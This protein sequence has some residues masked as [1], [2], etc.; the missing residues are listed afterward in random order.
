M[1][2][3]I[4]KKV[5]LLLSGFIVVIVVVGLVCNLL[6]LRQ[7]YVARNRLV[8][9]N[10]GNEVVAALQ[11]SGGDLEETISQLD[12]DN[13]V[14][15]RIVDAGG[16]I[17]ATSF[18]GKKKATALAD[19]IQDMISLDKGRR[20]QFAFSKV[21]NENGVSNLVHIRRISGGRYLV[22]NK[23]IKG[24]DESAA[25]ANRFYLIVGAGLILFGGGVTMLFSRAITKP[26]VEMSR[27]TARIAELDFSE[28]VQVDT[29]DELGALGFS[30]N[31]ISEKLS[32]S[33][34]RLRGDIARRKRLV[35]DLSHELKTPIAVIKGYA[36]GL[37]YGVA[38]DE[39][40]TARY[41][42]VI[43][44]ECDRMDAQIQQLLELS[45]LENEQLK[46]D[47]HTISIRG[48]FDSLSERFAREAEQKHIRLGFDA[49]ESLNMVA[50]E[51]MIGRAVE[52][53]LTNALRHTPESGEIRVHAE[54]EAGR[55]RICVFN[56][57]SHLTQEQ[58]ERIWDV[59][60]TGEN[61][62]R[63]NGHGVG[64]AIVKSIAQL[65]GGSVSAENQAE[66]V[67]FCI[68]IPRKNAKSLV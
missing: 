11:Q 45:R 22:L 37:Q 7:F 63:A 33:I 15:I 58:L 43:S 55:T 34:E 10:L 16:S 57:G 50:D 29:K 68:A 53:F 64:L 20:A 67:A 6:L 18:S 61:G 2:L 13:N 35:R 52:N 30:I 54:A 31:E 32:R 9:R 66:G 42:S 14:G 39:E 24:I 1:K 56:S 49:P 21:V 46:P 8:L 40:Q 48:L 5:F 28:R 4:R 47:L 25:T 26:I 12:W 38:Q 59:F 27:V 19:E 41:L 65:H 3:T 60:Y 51:A 17:L 23:S 44:A 36:E 62:D